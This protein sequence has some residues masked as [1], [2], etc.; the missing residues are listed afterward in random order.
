MG[1][2]K[3]LPKRYIMA[4][5]CSTSD[6]QADFVDSPFSSSTDVLIRM[7]GGEK[8]LEVMSNG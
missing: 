6:L 5:Y 1:R 3:L 2:G 8:S 4:D 7:A